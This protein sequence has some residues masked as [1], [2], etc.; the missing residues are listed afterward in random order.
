VAQNKAF[1]CLFVYL[2]T[3]KSSAVAASCACQ[4]RV[5]P[6]CRLVTL[7]AAPLLLPPATTICCCC[8]PKMLLPTTPRGLL[9]PPPPPA[10]PYKAASVSIV[11][12]SVPSLSWQ[13]EHSVYIEMIR[14]KEGAFVARTVA[15]V[16]WP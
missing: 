10:C 5:P 13:N 4:A 6:Q 7:P 11:P 14:E 8:C 9:S 2:R 15:K 12:V 16:A 3:G 1:V